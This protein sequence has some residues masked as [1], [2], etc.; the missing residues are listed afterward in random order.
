[1]PDRAVNVEIRGT[2]EL[3]RGAGRL[4]GNIDTAAQ[5]AFKRTADQAGTLVRSRVPHLTGR[6]AAS[7]ETDATDHGALVGMGAG[8]PYAGWIEFG[9]GHGRPYIATGR[10]VY[11]TALHSVATLQRA[12]EDAAR[13]EIR[14]M[15]WPVPT[16]L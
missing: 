13:S 9:G 7:V 12:G 15:A 6:L 10:Y 3:K 8:L 16:A 4:A 1:V 2:R 14:R 5:A 11:P